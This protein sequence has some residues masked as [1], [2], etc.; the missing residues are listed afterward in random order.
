MKRH[1]VLA[2][3]R[4][5][6]REFLREGAKHSI[7]WNPVTRSTSAVPPDVE[8]ADRLVLKI[9]KDLGIPEPS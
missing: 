7:D 5:H 9:G 8:I 6:G 4:R 2:H 3:L 1:A